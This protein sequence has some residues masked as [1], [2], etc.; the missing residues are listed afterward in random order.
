MSAVFTSQTLHTFLIRILKWP[1][2]DKV[3]SIVMATLR[4]LLFNS[5]FN[6]LISLLKGTLASVILKKL[7]GGNA[8]N[9]LSIVKFFLIGFTVSPT[10]FHDNI[11]LFEEVSEDM[12]TNKKP[13]S[14]SFLQEYVNFLTVLME[15]IHPGHP[16]LYTKLHE[17]AK[18]ITEKFNLL[19][20]TEQQ[21]NRIASEYQWLKAS[22]ENFGKLH[23]YMTDQL[24]SKKDTQIEQAPVK[25]K[26]KGLVNMGNSIF[27]SNEY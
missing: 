19:T 21:I 9:A 7:K 16:E 14:T 5:N 25:P 12:F 11:P 27:V 23:E 3:L 4:F 24:E 8:E 10:Y 15:K 2:T 6:I 22:E 18:S 20:L 17:L 26:H 13:L 1:T